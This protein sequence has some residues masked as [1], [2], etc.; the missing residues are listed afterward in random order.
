MS[1][2]S[3][4]FID[5][6]VPILILLGIGVLLQKKF[7]FRLRPIANLVTY[8]FMPAAVFINIY[9]AE[10]DV[11]LLAQLFIYLALFITIMII[12][13]N[14]FAKLLK[15]ERGEETAI[16]NSISLM[17]S[18]NYGL[19]VS[20]LVFS[21]HPL[22]VSVQVIVLVVQNLL[23]YTYGLYNLIS[24]SKSF[25]ELLRELMKLPIIYAL[26]LAALL[27]IF[28]L[29]I[30]NFALVPIEQL[31]G[32]FA[33]LALILLGMQL[34]SIQIRTFHRVIGWSLLG[35]LVLGPAVAFG[36][37]Y[38][39]GMDGVIAQSL[40]IASAFPTSRNTATLALEY[41]VEPELHAQVVLYST[42]LSS[43]T[44][45]FVIYL[46]MQLF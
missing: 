10:I 17:N 15:L 16:K 33:A 12:I 32:G 8:C 6:I 13:G 5:V 37:I 19:P 14:I 23:T 7:Q 9:H 39:L 36:L 42:L 24:A 4:V 35:R 38:M 20:Q 21:A 22:G 2:I 43:I 1:Y 44:V 29:P 28:D 11:S 45:T 26:V 40:L 3:L 46:A 27:K 18:G 34:E 25:I 30:P 41:D 31:A